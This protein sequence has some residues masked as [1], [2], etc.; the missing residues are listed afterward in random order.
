MDEDEK[1]QLLNHSANKKRP[2]AV[3]NPKKAPK[4]QIAEP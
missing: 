4:E 1:L 2:D 3:R